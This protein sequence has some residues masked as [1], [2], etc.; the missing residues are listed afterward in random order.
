[1]SSAHCCA[2]L[3][4]PTVFSVVCRLDTSRKCKCES[5]PTHWRQLANSDLTNTGHCTGHFGMFVTC[6]RFTPIKNN[7]HYKYVHVHCPVPR[8]LVTNR[9]R[10]LRHCGVDHIRND[11]SNIATYIYSVSCYGSSNHIW[12]NWSPEA[13]TTNPGTIQT[14][15]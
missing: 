5:M 4:P 13:P 8:S 6:M 14:H 7:F 1:M 11:S 12:L 9:Q 3:A 10:A 15:T 2:R